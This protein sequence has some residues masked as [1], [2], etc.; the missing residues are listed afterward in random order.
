MDEL[1]LRGYSWLLVYR[2]KEDLLVD[3]K[4]EV[5]DESIHPLLWWNLLL[6]AHSTPGSI[7]AIFTQN[8]K[9]KIREEEDK[10][11]KNQKKSYT[12]NRPNSLATFS[13]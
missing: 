11:V 6:L 7:P 4:L 5:L 13:K 1:E 2:Q 9:E 12:L 3:E 8:S 10:I